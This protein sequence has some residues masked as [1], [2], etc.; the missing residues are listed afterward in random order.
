MVM[1]YQRF[2]FWCSILV[3]NPCGRCVHRHR[4]RTV[5]G[6]VSP[7]YHTD[8]VLGQAI[9]RG[10]QESRTRGTL[11]REQESLREQENEGE[12]ERSGREESEGNEIKCSSACDRRFL[13]I[14][15]DI[16]ASCFLRLRLLAASEH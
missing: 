7:M 15:Q 9:A 11:A 5:Q 2:N 12:R 14:L 8:P 13:F 1:K 4:P 16:A 6:T 10:M 3:V